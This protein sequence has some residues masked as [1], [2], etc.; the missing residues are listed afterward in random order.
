M[1]RRES[2][3]WFTFPVVA[4][5]RQEPEARDSI[6]LDGGNP[7]TGTVFCCLLMGMGRGRESDRKWG[8]QNLN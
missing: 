8:T 4:A 5:A 7:S 6:H 1:R 2:I 3:L